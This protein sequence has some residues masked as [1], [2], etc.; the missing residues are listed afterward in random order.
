MQLRVE[1]FGVKIFLNPQDH[2]KEWNFTNRNMDI[3][4]EKKVLFYV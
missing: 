3:F 2:I 4:F 1:Q